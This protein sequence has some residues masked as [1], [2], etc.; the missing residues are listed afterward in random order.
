MKKIITRGILLLALTLSAFN[1]NSQ[2]VL[3]GNFMIDLYYGAPN[4]GKNLA[5]NFVGP[6]MIYDANSV[7][8][9]GPAGAR[10]EYM[11]SDNFG[12]GV[13]LIYNSTLFDILYDSLNQDNTVYTTY[14][15]TVAMERLRVHLR[16]NY[17]FELTDKLDVYTG[18]G[19][20]TNTRMWSVKSD[21]PGFTF[22]RTTPV[23][24]LPVS[25]RAAF[26]MR[27]YFAPNIGVNAE[28]GLGGPFVSA[29]LSIKI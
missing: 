25:M 21:Q 22:K 17:H 20:G 11:L 4:I 29:G 2:T 19:A 7:R 13:D 26:G 10:I 9:I 24:L 1:S 5:Q 28:I 18:L 8:G 27:Y 14:T 12:I 16:F 23:T 3:K 15:G 6:G